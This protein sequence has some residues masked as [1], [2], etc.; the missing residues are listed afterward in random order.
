MNEELGGIA[1]GCLF[2]PGR[3]LI[4]FSFQSRRS[5]RKPPVRIFFC[6]VIDNRKT[7]EPGR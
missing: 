7:H 4:L 2:R 3:D 6:F 5:M 1:D